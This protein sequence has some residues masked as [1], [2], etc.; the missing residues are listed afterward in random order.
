MAARDRIAL[1]AIKAVQAYGHKVPEDLAMV[2]FDDISITPFYTPPLTP[3]R[4][5]TRRTEELTAEKGMPLSGAQTADPQ[6]LPAGLALRSPRLPV[7][8]WALE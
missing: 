8:H 3:V 4:Q 1:V 7:A 5:D 6:V 2:G